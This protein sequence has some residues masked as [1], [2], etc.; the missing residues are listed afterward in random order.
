MHSSI[1]DIP[2]KRGR[3]FSGGR[4]S[5]VM[6]R[7]NPAQL[8]EL[9]AWRDN[10]SENLSRPEAIRRLIEVGLSAQPAPEKMRRKGEL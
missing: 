8:T 5:G 7:M 4:G 3:K 9:D 10:Q 6:V 2:K 1:A